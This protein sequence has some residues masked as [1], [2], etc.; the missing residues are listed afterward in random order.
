LGTGAAASVAPGTG[1]SLGSESARFTDMF[2]VASLRSVTND[3]LIE[4]YRFS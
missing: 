1:L 3:A 2:M 4:S